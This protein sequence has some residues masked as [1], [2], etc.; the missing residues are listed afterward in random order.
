[1]SSD[2]VQ[3]FLLGLGAGVL[4]AFFLKPP[5]EFDDAPPERLPDVPSAKDAEEVSEAAKA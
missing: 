4:V 3:G 5:S 2:K 1:M